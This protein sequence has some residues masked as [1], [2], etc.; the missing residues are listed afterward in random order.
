MEFWFL[1]ALAVEALL[2]LDLLITYRLRCR[3]SLAVRHCVKRFRNVLEV[4]MIQAG[5]TYP[6]V[7]RQKDSVVTSQLIAHLRR[8]SCEGKHS[9]LFRD[10]GPVVSAASCHKCFDQLRPHG[11]NSTCHGLT[12]LVVLL[13]QFGIRKNRADDRTS[14]FGWRRVHGSDDAF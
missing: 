11:L 4:V 1:V 7:T 6:S 14:M 9:N 10:M 5:D 8:H 12:F 3:D 13:S 2:C